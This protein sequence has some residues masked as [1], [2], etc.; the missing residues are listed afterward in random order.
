MIDINNVEDKKLLIIDDEAA[1]LD[2]LQMT[3]EKEGFRK[4]YRAATGE[5]GIALCHDTA[6][7]MIILDIMLPDINGYEVCRRIREMTLSPILFLSAKNEDTDKLLG[8]GVGGD[9]YITKPFSP[10]EV[11]FRVKAQFRRMEYSASEQ[12]SRL[13]SFGDIVID[14]NSCEVTKAGTPVSLTAKEYNLL[15]HL[16]KHPN[17]IFSKKTL[18]ETLWNEPYLGCDNVLMVHMRH[19]RE[20]LENDPGN[21]KYIITVKGL[22]YKLFTKGEQHEI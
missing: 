8:L 18:Y 21:P 9:D 12:S 2:I 3:F 16:A 1:I 13:L 7:D 11:A 17:Y 10:K 5:D 22:G 6:P 20:K 15:L 14:E 4:I 19:L